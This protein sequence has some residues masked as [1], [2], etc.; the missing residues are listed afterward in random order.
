MPDGE[1]GEDE[2]L[3]NESRAPDGVRPRG[4]VGAPAPGFIVLLLTAAILVGAASGLAVSRAAASTSQTQPGA[5]AGGQSG[6]EPAAEP[7]TEADPLTSQSYVDRL[8]RWEV[9]VLQ[10]GAVLAAAQGTELVLRSGR[11]AVVGSPAGGLADV[12][13]GKDLADRETAKANHLLIAPKGDGRG[14]RAVTQ[15]I[16]LVRGEY[17]TR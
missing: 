11:A 10:P 12:T 14:L 9:V 2:F 16:L 17:E 13:D 5:P 4:R 1:R 7:G 8:A 3:S 6:A 15:V